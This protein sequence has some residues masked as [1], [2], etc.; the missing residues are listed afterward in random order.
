MPGAES[1]GGGSARSR[2]FAA[3][4]PP[5]EAHLRQWLRARF[6]SVGDRDDLVREIFLRVIRAHAAERAAAAWA[7]RMADGLTPGEARREFP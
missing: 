6:P 4:V 1:V 5:H 2:W 7:L 3:E